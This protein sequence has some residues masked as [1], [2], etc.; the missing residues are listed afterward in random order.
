MTMRI[1]VAGMVA[2]LG[3]NWPSQTEI[4]LALG[5]GAAPCAHRLDRAEPLLTQ[6]LTDNPGKPVAPAPEL[7]SG[8]VHL[9]QLG[10]D[11]SLVFLP[12]AGSLCTGAVPEPIQPLTF[13]TLAPNPPTSPPQTLAESNRET[14]L[15]DQTITIT[16]APLT[17]PESDAPFTTIVNEM[18]SAFSAPQTIPQVAATIPPPP[19]PAPAPA[20]DL[21]PPPD[22]AELSTA[23]ASWDPPAGTPLE[24]PEDLY[25]G[26]AYELNKT[27][28]A[29]ISTPEPQ[30]NPS[31]ANHSSTRNPAATRRVVAALRL[32]GQALRAWFEILQN[33]AR[34]TVATA[35]LATD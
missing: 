5:L 31:A 22:A 14:T 27:A 3:I 8:L 12:D 11:P 7:A 19:P 21:P 18:A 23:Q 26:L 28:E 4:T 35:R 16:P 6:D 25:P 30:L 17:T 2:C 13:I 33:D 20:P 15:S 9:D 32:T 34:G 1:L 10:D 29:A 24:L